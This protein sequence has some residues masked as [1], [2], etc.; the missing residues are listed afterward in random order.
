MK[1]VL[2]TDW[3]REIRKDIMKV[4]S[5]YMGKD[6]VTDLDI[7][8][9]F[10]NDFE[11]FHGCAHL[12]QKLPIVYGVAGS[13]EII[14]VLEALGLKFPVL[15]TKPVVAIS[16]KRTA[17]KE[18]YWKLPA[19]QDWPSNLGSTNGM[20]VWIPLVDVTDELGPLEII[21]DSHLKGPLEHVTD[22]VPVLKDP[23]ESGWWPMPMKVGE[24]L[25]FNTMTIHRSGTNVTED[26]IRWSLHLR[27]NDAAEPSFIERK[28]P[29]NRTGD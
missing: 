19:H 4:F 23:P 7:M 13:D 28:Y 24:A 17:K 27:Y 20:T 9:L 29:R 8:K 26:R 2:M 3:V 21:P 5:T 11:G 15:N 10:E 6:S 12:C 14:R 16:S 1:G 25:F 22:T 18:V